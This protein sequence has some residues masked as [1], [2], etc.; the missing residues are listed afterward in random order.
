MEYFELINWTDLPLTEPSL[1][2]TMTD[3]EFQQ[4]IEMDVTP[5]IVFSEFFCHPQAVGIL[6]KVVTE[7]SK[8]VCGP[9]SRDRFIRARTA[10]RQLMP[11]FAGLS[12]GMGFPWEYYGK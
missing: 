1:L 2:K 9:K 5:P 8:A 4:F 3:T 11:R 12:M 7:V 6:M 10:S